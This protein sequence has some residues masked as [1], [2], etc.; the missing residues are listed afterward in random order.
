MQILETQIFPHDDRYLPLRW[1]KGSGL[2]GQYDHLDNLMLDLK[3]TP[4]YGMKTID[5]P[6]NS[7]IIGDPLNRVI[8][9]NDKANKFNTRLLSSAKSS[10]QQHVKLY[11]QQHATLLGPDGGIRGK[12]I[13]GTNQNAAWTLIT[14]SYLPQ[15][16]VELNYFVA[17]A[18]VRGEFVI[19][20][21]GI[22]MPDD[23]SN[24]DFT[25]SVQSVTGLT[26]DQIPNPDLFVNFQI[27]TD[28]DVNNL[29]TD[30][31]VTLDNYGGVK[32]LGDLL[33]AP[34]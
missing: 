5:K 23:G 17:Q 34:I 6:G 12:L 22:K 7:L 25:L 21:S 27:S 15:D 24:P 28:I 26:P 18:D 8:Q 2:L 16:S 13:I 20:L 9:L 14:A 33:I 31:T 3:I 32:Q 11:R 1:V 30:I 10:N 4:A 29:A 19:D